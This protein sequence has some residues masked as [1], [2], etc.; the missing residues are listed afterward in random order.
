MAA[1]RRIYERRGPSVRSSCSSQ[2]R[3]VTIWADAWRRSRIV[4][5][6][7]R[8]CWKVFRRFRSRTFFQ[9]DSDHLKRH[10]DEARQVSTILRRL[11]VALAEGNAESH[12]QAVDESTGE[13]NVVLRKSQATVDAWQS[14]LDE[15]RGDLARVEPSP[16]VDRD[17][18]REP[19]G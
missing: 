19:R 11:E 1:G 2:A 6:L 15:T 13:V 12:R 16:D 7:F 5:S 10:A 4:P 18:M 14:D 9:I 8:A 17:G 3:I